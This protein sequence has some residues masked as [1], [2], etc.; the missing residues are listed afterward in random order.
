M[1]AVTET[2]PVI[3]LDAFCGEHTAGRADFIRCDV[4]GS[5]M[6]VLL[7]AEQLIQNH[8]PN[9]LIEIHPPLLAERFGTTGE[10]VRD[11]VLSHGY[12]MFY[13]DNGTMVERTELAPGPWK[14]YFFLHPSRAEALPEGPLRRLMLAA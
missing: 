8:H 5:E 10:A 9:L 4:E 12:R 14:D 11:W 1:R 2:V 6:D 3:T 13:L 7:G